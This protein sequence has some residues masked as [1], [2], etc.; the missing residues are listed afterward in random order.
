MSSV[1]ADVVAY[2]LAAGLS[3]L[4]VLLTLVILGTGNPRGNG[5]AFLGGFILT[6]A[7]VTLGVALVGSVLAPDDREPVVQTL[8]KLALGVVSLAAAWHERPGRDRGEGSAERLKTMLARLDGLTLGTAFF[9]GTA[10]AVAPKRLAITVL[11][12]LTIGQ[13]ALPAGPSI[14]LVVVYVVLISAPIW[15]LLGGYV[16]AGERS[17]GA[18][19]AIKEWVIASAHPIAFVVSLVFGLLFT[20]QALAELVA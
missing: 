12:G 10:L 15:I 1:A 2:G 4:A 7:A 14:A 18:A 17:D 5:F 13:A 3:V 16:L 11:A 9:T 8:L 20:A 19:A 6:A